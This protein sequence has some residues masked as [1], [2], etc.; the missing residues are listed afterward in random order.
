MKLSMHLGDDTLY[1]ARKVEIK[2][3]LFADFVKITA[4][5]QIRRYYAQTPK[6]N[7][8]RQQ[9]REL[10]LRRAGNRTA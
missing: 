2:A 9:V 7:L 1:S 10:I 8:D 4:A 3:P 5:E 6:T